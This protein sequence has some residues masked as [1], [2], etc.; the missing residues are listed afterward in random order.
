MRTSSAPI[1]GDFWIFGL[2]KDP[3]AFL[4]GKLV[5]HLGISP[6]VIDFG[7][8]GHFFFYTTYGDLVETEQ[9]IALKVGL[10]HSPAGETLSTRQLLDRGIIR[11]TGIKAEELR[12][13]GL[14]ACFSKTTPELAVYKTVLS[15]PQLYYSTHEQTLLCT[16][17]PQP[18]LALLD[19]VEPN[20]EAVV[21][22]FLFRY[23]LGSYTYF[24]NICRLLSG[25]L[26]TWNGDRLDLRLIRDLRS[27]QAGPIFKR[28]DAES[29]KAL[30]LEMSRLLGYY[31][32]DIKQTNYGLGTMLSGGVDSSLIQ[33]FINDHLPEVEQRHTYSY[34][35]RVPEFDFE[36]E[37]AKDAARA[38]ETNHTIV[39][40][41]PEQYP[42]LLI[43]TIETLCYP[44]PAESQ[45]CKMAI[46]RYL[47]EH[48]SPDR[49]FFVGTGADTLYGTSLAKKMTLLNTVRN[50]PLSSLALKSLATMAG[51]IAPKKAH[52]LRE[53][54]DILPEI[55]DPYSYKVPANTIAVYTNLDLARR[56]FGDEALKKALIYRHQMEAQYLDSDHHIE[57]V[58]TLE[59]I[60]DAYETAVLVNHLYLAY[61]REQIY[62]YL[63]EQTITL[64]HRFDANMRYHK[65]QQ[66]KPLLKGILE[67]K[68]LSAIAHK[69]KGPSVFNTSLHA[70]MREGGQM[71]DMVTGIDRP[72]FLDQ[73]EFNKLL[74]VPQ[75][76]DLDSPDW[77][78][79]NLLTFDIFNKNVINAYP[80]LSR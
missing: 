78:L 1:K 63:D 27:K 28:V 30:Y 55:N 26:L 72:G 76:H 48:N 33:L 79:W 14:I 20:E 17:G 67:Q 31:V 13:N 73:K 74:E 44:I 39:D 34:A 36:I 35:I 56:C 45:P 22:H 46:A 18:H 47:A 54:A 58:H 60:T 12:G 50:V 70:W 3:Q 53:I 71:R 49:Y 66:V 16:D 57:K 42:D 40:V 15:M 25:Q 52:G 64:S 23:A 68:S 6:T 62:P 61:Q 21:Q 11:P 5:P 80:A 51:P 8:R 77:F 2:T 41:Y 65:G 38:L 10:V 7:D 37:Y 69:P 24:K 9:V 43:E 59:L 32:G 19:R 4:Q 29:I 75:W